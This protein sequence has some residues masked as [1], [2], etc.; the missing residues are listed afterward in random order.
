[1]RTGGGVSNRVPLTNWKP[2]RI[3]ELPRMW[4]PHAPQKWRSQRSPDV[5]VGCTYTTGVPCTTTSASGRAT[6]SEATTGRNERCARVLGP[7]ALGLTT[8]AALLAARAVADDG[9]GVLVAA[10]D[11]HG[12]RAADAGTGDIGRRRHDDCVGWWVG[13][14]GRRGLKL[15]RECP[16]PSACFI[17]HLGKDSPRTD[18]DA[19]DSKLT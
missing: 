1:M 2:G 12:D 7:R 13:V 8:A 15:M 16:S 9:F 3:P 11:G 14:R 6:A 4:L 18:S 10:L 17:H 19:S 5:L